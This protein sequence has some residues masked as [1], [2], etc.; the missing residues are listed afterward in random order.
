MPVEPAP[1][2]WRFPDP[3]EAPEDLVAFGGDLEPG[4]ILAAYRHGIFPMPIE[5][6]GA[7]EM[8]WWSPVERAVLPVDGLRVTRSMRRSSRRLRTTI[9]Q[10]FDD[11]LSACAD[12]RRPGGWIDGRIA[13]G[14]GEL[15]RLGW[16]HSV[17]VWRD[18]DLVG[19]LYGMAIAGLFA[20]ESMFHR[21]T[22]A[23]KVALMA[24]VDLLDDGLPGRV[25]DVQWLTPHLASLGAVTVGRDAYLHR[26]ETALT[27]PPPAPFT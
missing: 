3:R 19:G 18:D 7:G 2:R 20:G 9:D 23:S 15:A 10:C 17:E 14:Y 12:P 6:G 8:A 4:T 26:L 16:A 25:L 21:V 24:L 13:V 5:E 1:T 27:L 11:V 22:D